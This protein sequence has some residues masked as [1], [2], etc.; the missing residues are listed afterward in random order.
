V[1]LRAL[2]EVSGQRTKQGSD[3]G[4]KR[5]VWVKFPPPELKYP[6]RK[7]G[8]NLGVGPRGIRMPSVL[9]SRSNGET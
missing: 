8:A 5:R 3:C 1:A 9:M 4:Y 6:R 7:N 2:S